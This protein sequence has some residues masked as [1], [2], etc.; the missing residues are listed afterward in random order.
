M[1]LLLLLLVREKKK[2]TKNT[3]EENNNFL[4]LMNIVHWISKWNFWICVQCMHITSN[5]YTE[6]HTLACFMSALVKLHNWVYCNIRFYTRFSILILRRKFNLFV[7]L[8][9]Y[10][11][12]SLLQLALHTVVSL[13]RIQFVWVF[14]CKNARRAHLWMWAYGQIVCFNRIANMQIRH[15]HLETCNGSNGFASLSTWLVSW[16]V[17]YVAVVTSAVSIQC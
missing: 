7:C 1:L 13:L 4:S 14:A 8:P 2:K 3:Y 9:A 12:F 16:F 10:T 15:R 6:H 5:P 11:I 17:A